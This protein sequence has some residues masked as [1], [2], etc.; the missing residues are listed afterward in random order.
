MAILFL[1]GP[2]MR[3]SGEDVPMRTRREI[4]EVF[5]ESGHRVILMEDEADKGDEDLVAKFYRLLLERSVTDIVV[6]WP[7]HAKM[8]T[9]YDELILLRARMD[10]SK[11][12]RIW[13]LHHS[14]VASIKVGQFEVKER[15]S[16]SRYLTAVAKLGTH[17]LEWDSVEDLKEQ[18][19][20]LAM[21]L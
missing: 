10:I 12:S 7:A 6:Y 20:L 1:L 4:G 13:V 21:E 19:R 18:V 5:R 15:G 9:T 8:Q 14:S 11:Q 2:S 3:E 16:R 17:P